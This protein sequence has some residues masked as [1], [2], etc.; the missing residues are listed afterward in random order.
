MKVYAG[1]SEPECQVAARL[2]GG[3]HLP[4][5]VSSVCRHRV[6]FFLLFSL[7]SSKRVKAAGLH[8]QSMLGN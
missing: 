1:A 2:L 5:Q 7:D 8:S 4:L 3:C 6:H